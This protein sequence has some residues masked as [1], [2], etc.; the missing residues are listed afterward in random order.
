[1]KHCEIVIGLRDRISKAEAVEIERKL[2]GWARKQ[3][4]LPKDAVRFIKVCEVGRFRKKW[5]C[6]MAAHD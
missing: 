3:E 5:I 4:F 2:Y 1:M 6:W